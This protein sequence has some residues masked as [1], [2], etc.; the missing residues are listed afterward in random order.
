MSTRLLIP[1]SMI[2]GQF[3]SHPALPVGATALSVR[4][5]SPPR[6]VSANDKLNIGFVGIGGKGA[7]DL[8][9]CSGENVVALCDVDANV[10]DRFHERHPDAKTYK[11]FRKMLEEQEKSLDP[12]VIATP[13]H[14]HASVA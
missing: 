5:Q 14:L 8:Q 10:L 4:G 7:S 1:L 11:D 9:H 6:R 12:V 13:D 2:R 3:I